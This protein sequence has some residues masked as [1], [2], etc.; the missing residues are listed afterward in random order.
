MEIELQVKMEGAEVE[1]KLQSW[2]EE[3]CTD[4]KLDT[5][6]NKV[7]EMM[8]WFESMCDGH[9]GRKALTKPLIEWESGGN[10]LVYCDPYRAD[11][12]A[13]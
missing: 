8:N 5:H 13:R 4:A 3:V 10:R 9:F 12:E 6:F 2:R 11:P 7:T 1:S